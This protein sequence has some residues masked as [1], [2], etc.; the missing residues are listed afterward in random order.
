[1]GL[2]LVNGEGSAGGLSLTS[3]GNG[4]FKSSWVNPIILL[5]RQPEKDTATN[6][7]TIANAAAL[8]IGIIVKAESVNNPS[9][10]MRAA[11]DDGQCCLI[12][13]RDLERG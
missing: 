11:N 2:I 13:I 4:K 9:E 3:A 12:S 1:V 6:A 7:K 5:D 8:F 10:C